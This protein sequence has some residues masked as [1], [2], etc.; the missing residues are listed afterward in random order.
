MSQDRL[1]DD[2]PNAEVITIATVS[3]V[4]SFHG[5]VSV[6]RAEMYDDTGSCD[7]VWFSRGG[8]GR[9]TLK[10]GMR[11]FLHGRIKAQRRGGEWRPELSVSSHRVLKPE[12]VYQG[13]IWPVY[14]ASKEL[15]SRILARVIESNLSGLLAEIGPEWLPSELLARRGYPSPRDAWHE[16]HSPASLET[17]RLARERIAFSTFFELA[18]AALA[19]RAALRQ[20]GGAVALPVPGDLLARFAA[21]LPFALTAAQQRVITEIWADMATVAPMHRLLQGDVGS[22]KTVVAAAACVLAGIAGLQSALMAPTEL[23]ARQHA[24]KLAPLLL[25]FGIGLEYITGSQGARARREA[26]ERVRAG[27][28]TLV[29]GTHALLTERVTFANLALVIIDEQHRFGVAQRAMLRNKNDAVHTLAMTATPIPRTLAQTRYADLDF[30]VID[31]LP[32]GRTPIKTYIRNE[33]SKP[34]IYDFLRQKVAEGR[35]AYIVAPVIEEG[36]SELSSALAEAEHVRTEI[37]PDLRVGLV[38]GRM[39]ARERIA[40]MERFG[41]GEIDILIATTVVEVGVDVPNA[42]IMV[43]L[44]AYRFGLAQLHQLR[45]R[46]GRGA[47]AAV[48]IL[49]A[50]HETKRLRVLTETT[51]GFRI[52]DADL[53]IRGEGE[54]AGTTQAGTNGVIG[55]ASE[56]IQLYLE[57]RGEAEAILER[58]PQLLE[59]E[60]RPL[61]TFREQGYSEHALLLSS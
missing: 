48:C 49:V 40:E 47:E 23:L 22:G 18:F 7:A 28:A 34:R 36:E 61:Q 6:V 51:D 59:P 42:S 15:P 12:D 39:L 53:E 4:E 35:Q 9:V 27:G 17:L 50:E 14:P 24:Q 8:Y 44:D 32:P 58:D 13:K 55:T 38:H 37:F 11:L 46:V 25:P 1:A 21:E 31:E 20:A 60:H 10:S 19:R 33:A 45:G 43:I 56:D 57:A 29:V 54:F 26:E 30:S 5:R 16:L 52:A 3:K 41:R 2:D